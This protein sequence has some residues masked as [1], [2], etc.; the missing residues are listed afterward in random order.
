MFDEEHQFGMAVM[1]VGIWAVIT[2]QY[3]FALLVPSSIIVFV[4]CLAWMK[5]ELRVF[6]RLASM[7]RVNPGLRGLVAFGFSLWPLVALFAIG[8]IATS[9]GK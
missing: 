4:L 3:G 5:L 8:I 7:H 9:G 6:R 1:A 2:F